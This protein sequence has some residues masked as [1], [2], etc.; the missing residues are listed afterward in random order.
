MTKSDFL[1]ILESFPGRNELQRGKP[2]YLE[3]AFFDFERI[4]NE[5]KRSKLNIDL[6]KNEDVWIRFLTFLDISNWYITDQENSTLDRLVLNEEDI[7]DEKS[8]RISKN[9]ADQYIYFRDK[10]AKEKG[11]LIET[12]SGIL[13]QELTDFVQAGKRFYFD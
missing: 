1:K 8:L 5:I 7:L 11:D 6:G 10:N 12:A 13:L 2:Q 4:A 3:F 9:L